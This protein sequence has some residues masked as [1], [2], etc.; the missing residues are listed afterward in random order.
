[1]GTPVLIVCDVRASGVTGDVEDSYLMGVEHRPSGG[2]TVLWTD[3]PD[4]AMVF[5]DAAA[6]AAFC[7]GGPL[8]V[9]VVYTVPASGHPSP[10]PVP[11]APP[12]EPINLMDEIRAMGWL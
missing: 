10:S 12:A 11:P 6:A 2:V 9:F 7:R 4:Q 3:L 8:E 5:D 1:M